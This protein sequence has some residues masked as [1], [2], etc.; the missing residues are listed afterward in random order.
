MCSLYGY[1]A[2]SFLQAHS[3]KLSHVADVVL[4]HHGL[5]QKEQL[6]LQIISIL[7][8]PAPEHFRPQLRRLAALGK[9]LS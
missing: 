9:L 3:G 7:V 2:R 1:E 4:S 6:T 8:Q 5:K